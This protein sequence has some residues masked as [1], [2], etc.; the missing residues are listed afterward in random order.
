[1][2]LRWS[3]TSAGFELIIAVPGRRPTSVMT[4]HEPKSGSYPV[5]GSAWG[6]LNGPMTGAILL[7]M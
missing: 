6:G 2:P 1:M 4:S 7:L 5:A 3:K